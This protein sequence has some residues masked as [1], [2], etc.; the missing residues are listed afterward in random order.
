MPMN[1]SSSRPLIKQISFSVSLNMRLYISSYSIRPSLFKPGPPSERFLPITLTVF[2]VIPCNLVMFPKVNVKLGEI[3]TCSKL[4][5]II[6]WFENNCMRGH[7]KIDQ[8]RTKFHLN[9]HNFWFSHSISNYISQSSSYYV[10]NDV[11]FPWFRESPKF[12]I[13]FNKTS[14]WHYRSDFWKFLFVFWLA[15]SSTITVQT[16][17]PLI[18]QQKKLGLNRDKAWGVFFT[19]PLRFPQ[20]LY[21]HRKF[22]WNFVTFQNQNPENR[23]F[24]PAIRTIFSERF[25]AGHCTIWHKTSIFHVKVMFSQYFDKYPNIPQFAKSFRLIRPELKIDQN[26]ILTSYQRLRRCRNIKKC[27]SFWSYILLA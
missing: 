9:G 3:K 24:L 14:L 2:E 22:S 10:S 27:F 15:L 19:C 6:T 4:A 16:L 8:N 7:G 1:V 11:S 21:N 26:S 23:P 13:V 5:T 12:A 25:S 17:I 18:K 20:Y